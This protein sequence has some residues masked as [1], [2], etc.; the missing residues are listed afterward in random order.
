[1]LLAQLPRCCVYAHRP[2]IALV[3]A[4]LLL[5][6]EHI[7]VQIEEV[8]ACCQKV[9]LLHEGS[10]QDAPSNPFPILPVATATTCSQPFHV[11]AFDAFCASAQRNV[12][13]AA[14]MHASSSD[15]RLGSNVLVVTGGVL[16]STTGQG[17]E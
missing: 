14:S 1:M 6:V 11:L 17:T 3:I 13:E 9:Q 12:F 16:G 7:G 8:R 10:R 4:F 15:G 5:G 2:V